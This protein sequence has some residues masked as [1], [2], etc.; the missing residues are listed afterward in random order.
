MDDLQ[1]PIFYASSIR[2]LAQMA[3]VS[4]DIILS[5][6]KQRKKCSN[7]PVRF[8]KVVFDDEDLFNDFDDDFGMIFD[9]CDAYDADDVHTA[10]YHVGLGKFDRRELYQNADH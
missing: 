1:L 2:E 8:I 7:R 9:F 10:D 6:V 5:F 4:S 3:K